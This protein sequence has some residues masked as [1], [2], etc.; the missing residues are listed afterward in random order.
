MLKRSVDV[1]V[2][3][4]ARWKSSGETI[5][6]AFNKKAL[7]KSQ[8]IFNPKR[9]DWCPRTGFLAGTISQT[10]PPPHSGISNGGKGER[11]AATPSF[12][13]ILPQRAFSS[14]REWC[15]SWLTSR[16]LRTASRQACRGLSKPSLTLIWMAGGIYDS[17]KV[18]TGIT[19]QC[20]KWK[21]IYSNF[22]AK[23][24]GKS[25]FLMSFLCIL[26]GWVL[27]ASFNSLH[28]HYLIGHSPCQLSVHLAV[29][30]LP[31]R[32]PALSKWRR[33]TSDYRRS[34]T[35]SLPLSFWSPG[36]SYMTP[37]RADMYFF[38]ATQ[39]RVKDKSTTAIWQWKVHC[40]RYI[41]IGC[42]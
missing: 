26:A 24:C 11:R 13:Q 16:F 32:S 28:H 1:K 3:V 17:Q 6:V 9:K 15:W 41:Q 40:K 29:S 2:T 34:M 21:K 19:P 7:A 18:W 35:W 25:P 12:H 14:F 8:L 20:L 22:S 36:E 5:D 37:S 38:T 33:G 10:L 39:I 27:F 23:K 31:S 42:A 30:K 4:A